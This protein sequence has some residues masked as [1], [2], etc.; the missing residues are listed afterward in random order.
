[1]SKVRAARLRDDG[2][3]TPFFP[4][5]DRR[6]E[7]AEALTK[8]LA[9]DSGSLAAFA[10]GH[11]H[12]G[13]HREADGTWCFRDWAPNATGVCLMGSF[14]DWKESAAYEAKRTS[15]SGEWELKLPADAMRHGDLFRLRIRWE[16]GQG[17]RL[18]AW[19]RRVVQDEVTKAFDAQVWVPEQPFAW[20]NSAPTSHGPLLIYEAHA[21]MA[22]E[23]PKTGTWDEFRQNI[24]PRIKQ[25]GYNT[26]QLMAVQEH[27]YYG[28][29]GYHV[30]SFFAPSSRFGTPE[31]LKEMIDEAHGMGLRVIMDL[32]HSH[33][34]KN[35]VEGISRYDG[36]L[37]QFFH[38]GDRGNHH[39]WD[40]RCFDYARPE[41]VHFLLS[42]IR[43]WL[44]EFHFDG[45]RFDGVTSMLYHDH[46][47]GSLFTSYDDYFGGRVDEDAV[48]YLTLATTLMHEVAPGSIAIAEDVSGMAGLAASPEEGGMGFDFRLSMGVPDTWFKL[49]DI[50]DEDWNMA[51]LWHELTNHRADERVISYVESHDQALVG[52]KSFIFTLIDADMYW[53]MHATSL[54]MIVDRGVALHKLARMTTLGTAGHGYLNFMGNEFGHPEWVDFPREG[55]GW[56]F[57]K[58]RRKWSLRDNPGL[59]FKHLADFD[60]G[61]LSLVSDEW[62]EQPPVLIKADDGDK[63]L[64]WKRADLVFLVSFHPVQ[65]FEGYG[66]QLNGG[67]YD[68]V[69]SSDEPKFGGFARVP[70]PQ[71]YECDAEGWLRVYLPSRTAIVLRSRS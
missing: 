1:M 9:K 12:F 61:M 45:F 11:K 32:V 54:S 71:R 67:V 15:N 27:P 6:R 29:F 42:N 51:W 33:A 65:S 35:E 36:T 7:Q 39:A 19:G 22:Q 55:N 63:V 26:V 16:G 62:S 28:S 50:R 24:L 56:S 59:R 13:L 47:L 43:Y 57:D 44:E 25:A 5:L 52:G 69:M 34:V 49:T 40:S 38:A 10:Q 30:S 4:A 31:E 37:H 20:K 70:I 17:D 58:A 64:A 23:E 14:N 18:P 2:W 3:L 21:G 53:N 68:L 60:E 8:R 48:T 46:G 41:V 66:F